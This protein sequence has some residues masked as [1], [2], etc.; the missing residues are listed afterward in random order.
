MLDEQ[1]SM[2]PLGIRAENFTVVQAATGSGET[3]AFGQMQERRN[4]AY[5]LRSL[6]VLPEHRCAGWWPQGCVR[7]QPALWLGLCQQHART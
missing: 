6:V 4:G 2:N 5:E 1:R 7:W 3:L